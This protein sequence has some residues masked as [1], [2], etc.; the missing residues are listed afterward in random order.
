MKL[1]KLI[2]VLVSIML[3]S[4]KGVYAEECSYIEQSNISKMA[5]EVKAG[6]TIKE[7]VIDS[8]G[9]IV[10]DADNNE[11][12][13]MHETYLEVNVYNITDSLYVVIKDSKDKIVK[14]IYYAD[15]EEGTYTFEHTDLSSIITYK[16]DV[17]S[18]GNNG[19]EKI[20]YRTFMLKLPKFNPYYG[21]EVCAGID[22]FSGCKMLIENQ[23]PSF[24]T[25]LERIKRYKDPNYGK[26]TE[27][28]EEENGSFNLVRY[29]W[30]H[31]ILSL[32]ILGFIIILIVLFIR[33]RKRKKQQRRH[34]REV[35]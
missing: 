34:K 22:D 28:E 30:T 18:S 7:R 23:E 3:F 24:N 6:Y 25:L 33:I 19:C 15:T 12:V 13:E 10:V 8:P 9:L 4:L 2:V 5:A 29:L 21:Y 14:T 32:G 16:L 20:K 17:Y 11:S 27:L 1:R 26:E 35:F 31:K